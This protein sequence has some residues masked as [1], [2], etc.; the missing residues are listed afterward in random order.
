VPRV[1]PGAGPSS[2]SG[3]AA[4]R[5][6]LHFARD[7]IGLRLARALEIGPARLRELE[8][9]VLC[10]PDPLDLRRGVEIFRSSR[11]AL[12][13]ARVELSP[14]WFERRAHLRG[15]ELRIDGWL[16]GSLHVTIDDGHGPLGCLLHLAFERGDLLFV[17]LRLRGAIDTPLHPLRRLLRSARTLGLEFDR[18]RGLLRLER[19]LRALL[20]ELLMPHGWRVPEE[21]G[22][23]DIHLEA[24]GSRLTLLA[25]ASPNEALCRAESE[26]LAE[27]R[28]RAPTLL[29]AL[30]GAWP[31]PALAAPLQALLPGFA[32]GAPGLAAETQDP[33][34]STSPGSSI[35]AWARP[36]LECRLALRRGALGAA[37]RAAQRLASIEPSRSL[38]AESLAQTAIAI[39]TEH[40]RDAAT[41]LA[42]AASLSRPEPARFERWIEAAAQTGS[43]EA[44]A[45]LVELALR[46]SDS[47][48]L[49]GWSALDRGR[50]AASACIALAEHASADGSRCARLAAAAARLDPDSH[51]TFRARALAAARAG[52][53]EECLM[54]LREAGERALEARDPRAAARLYLELAERLLAQGRAPEA[55]AALLDASIRSARDPEILLALAR[56]IAGRG[57]TR[58]A[59]RLCDALLDARW[60]RRR[61]T[62]PL[63]DALAF[64]A[65]LALEGYGAE[66]ARPFVL[67][68]ERLAPEDPRTSS[69]GRGL[70]AREASEWLDD[71]DALR[72]ADAELLEQLAEVA[73]PA[74]ALPAFLEAAR[75]SEAPLPLL[76]AALRLARRAADPGP[77]E[78]LEAFLRDLP[79]RASEGPL[80]AE[81]ASALRLARA[82]ASRS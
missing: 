10:A 7:A 16:E 33:L 12:S 68:L 78:Q 51:Q 79:E 11:S 47:D 39:A 30:E 62:V 70:A 55:E 53:A 65:E 75:S 18:R 56:Q 76:E 26:A 82:P 63:L 8:L 44:L 67:R 9:R 20:A 35:P 3:P 49:R 80:R 66:E 74:T 17:P 42:H 69:L 22:C 19:P 40:P 24:R 23:E 60:E 52:R 1:E 13:L 41:L 64:A 37:R 29:E 48:E 6:D 15:I 61:P 77:L 71:P 46:W 5:F 36:S 34:G 38:A 25:G 50:I 28:R 72:E 57:E 32:E 2:S 73:S 4:P 81:L 21:R 45:H 59:L 31:P 54:R 58:D 27:A 14:R 43:D